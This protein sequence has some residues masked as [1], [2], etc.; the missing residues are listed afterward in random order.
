MKYSEA[1]EL[2]ST[3]SFLRE[4]S[5]GQHVKE[6]KAAARVLQARFLREKLRLES[7][8]QKTGY[9]SESLAIY[10]TFGAKTTGTGDA[11]RKNLQ[12]L[13]NLN[14]TGEAT[15]KQ[16][17]GA[18]RDA[19]I[20]P[21][22][23]D[24]I[25]NRLIK[26]GWKYAEYIIGSAIWNFLDSLQRQEIVKSI[27]P[28]AADTETVRKTLFDTLENVNETAYAAYAVK[29]APT[30]QTPVHGLGYDGTIIDGYEYAEYILGANTYM[31]LSQF[32]KDEIA[33]RIEGRDP[34]SDYTISDDIHEIA[35]RRDD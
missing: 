24:A 32:Q 1:L 2:V 15:V 22:N 30:V 29:H 31:R 6:A 14:T 25:S 20:N 11:L 16:V 28:D 17:K 7:Y 8:E 21:D 3:P 27:E 13:I 23:P 10:R 26:N 33:S 35:F 12:V 19:G 9:T 18:L 4:V 5:A 34:D